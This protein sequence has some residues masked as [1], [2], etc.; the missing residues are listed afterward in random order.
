MRCLPQPCLGG[1][2]CS[3]NSAYVSRVSGGIGGED[4]EPQQLV[5]CP[6]K[7]SFIFA[8]LESQESEGTVWC[9][10][11]RATVQAKPQCEH[12]HTVTMN[13]C[14]HGQCNP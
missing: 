6:W 1:S 14:D 8:L 12:A 13:R 5:G 4:I 7:A 9:G 3:T 10:E 11:S 2:L